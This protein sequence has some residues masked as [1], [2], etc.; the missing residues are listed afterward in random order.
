MRYR[1]YGNEKVKQT[2]ANLLPSE[3]AGATGPATRSDVKSAARS[4]VKSAANNSKEVKIHDIVSPPNSRLSN[5]PFL[6]M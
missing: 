2:L 5:T 3:I 1:D 4:D 6:E